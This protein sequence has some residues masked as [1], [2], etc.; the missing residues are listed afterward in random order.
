MQVAS[1]VFQDINLNS[2]LLEKLR[3]ELIDLK[4][5]YADSQMELANVV[6]VDDAGEE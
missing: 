2:G 1:K 3:Q 4:L 6:A 5:K